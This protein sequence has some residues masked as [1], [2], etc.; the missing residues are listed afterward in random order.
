MIIATFLHYA[1]IALALLCSVGAATRAVITPARAAATQ[2]VEYCMSQR[3][4][5]LIVGFDF[6]VYQD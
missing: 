5:D 2:F 6:V 4:S 1:G 3:V